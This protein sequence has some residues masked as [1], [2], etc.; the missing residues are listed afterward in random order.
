MTVI[1]NFE[2]MFEIVFNKL[3]KLLIILKLLFKIRFM[4]IKRLR[5]EQSMFWSKT[6]KFIYLE[7]IN[8]QSQNKNKRNYISKRPSDYSLHRLNDVLVF[9]LNVYLIFQ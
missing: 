9:L 2:S 6:E 8:Q 3:K 5:V 1:T 7:K 4:V